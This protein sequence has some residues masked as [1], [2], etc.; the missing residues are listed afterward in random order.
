MTA[1][2]PKYA[3]TTPRPAFAPIEAA[4]PRMLLSVAFGQ[5]VPF[6]VGEVVVAWW[7]PG[8]EWAN[9]NLTDL[10]SGPAMRAGSLSS[11]VTPWGGLNVAGLDHRGELTVYWWAPGLNDWVISPLSELLTGDEPPAGR[12]TGISTPTGQINLFGATGGGDVV[13]YYWQPEAVWQ[14]E[15]VSSG[16]VRR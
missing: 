1:S 15:N 11:Y 4:E 14:A 16:A 10:F 2:R 9:S 6:D 5:P 3:P 12:V 8:A 7:V 13:R